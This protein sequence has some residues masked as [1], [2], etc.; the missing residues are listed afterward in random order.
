MSGTALVLY[1]TSELPGAWVG[2][3]AL[4]AGVVTEALA[5]QIM[6]LGTVRELKARERQPDDDSPAHDGYRAIAAFY[7]PLALT[8]LIGLT[9]QPMLTF[10]MG[11]APAPIE[12]LAVFPVVHSL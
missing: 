10:F 5:T 11:R 7:Y 3:S 4:S 8:S 9:V 2:A 1:F 12:S 6:A